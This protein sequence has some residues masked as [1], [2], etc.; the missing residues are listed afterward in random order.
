MAYYTPS[1]MS[2]MSGSGSYPLPWM[3]SPMPQYDPYATDPALVAAMQ[4]QGG[5]SGA[6]GAGPAGLLASALGAGGVKAVLGN[7]AGSAAAA[8]PAA[9]ATPVNPA[10]AN[11][12]WNAAGMEASGVPMTL[13]ET[14]TSAPGVIPPGPWQTGLGAAGTALGAYM[15]AQGI[16]N[17]DPMGAALG[18]AGAGLGLNAMGYALG[19][20]GWAAMLAAPAAGALINKMTDKDRWKEEQSAV[21]KLA[22]D[23]VIG[24]EQYAATQPRLSMGRSKGELLD[25]ERAKAAAG[26]YANE[27]FAQSRDEKDLRGKDIWG[28]SAFGKKF[29]NDWFGSFSEK[30]REEIAQ[31]A[32]DENAVNETRGQ[33]KVN[34]SNPELAR[35]IEENVYGRKS[36]SN[37]KPLNTSAGLPGGERT[38]VNKGSATN[39]ITKEPAKNIKGQY[40]AGKALEKFRKAKD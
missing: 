38:P 30:Q 35:Y 22:K 11:A 13:A 9:L 1:E 28:F 27:K 5:A 29:G 6:G 15:A 40:Q 33:I 8:A 10:S 24:W 23:G 12:L 19:P 17:K 7:S 26:Q 31:K 14:G 32:I 3:A 25:I 36:E 20:W 21:D 16:K 34:W 39:A 18:G 4:E 2:L 37:T